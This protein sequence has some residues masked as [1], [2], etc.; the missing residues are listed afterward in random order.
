MVDYLLS[1]SKVD[2][3]R[4]GSLGIY[5]DG[6]TLAAAETDKRIQAVATLSMF[7]SGRV[8]RNGFLD[9]D[10]AGIRKRLERAAEARNKELQGVV[11]YEGFLPPHKDDDE[12]RTIMEKWKKTLYTR[13]VLNIMI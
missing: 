2:P 10:K 11:T 9:G 4:I 5:V 7:H 13:M 8:R 6:Y 12:L 1:L 3:K